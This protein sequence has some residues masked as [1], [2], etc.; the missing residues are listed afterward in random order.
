M[1]LRVGFETGFVFEK[2]VVAAVRIE[3][4]VEIDE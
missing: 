4:R 2:D 1:Y 3:R